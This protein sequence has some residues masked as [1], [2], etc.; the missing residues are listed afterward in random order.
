M[1]CPIALDL[2]TIYQ[3]SASK[4]DSGDNKKNHNKVVLLFQGIYKHCAKTSIVVMTQITIFL[5][6]HQ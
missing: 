2:D 4:F 6:S 3:V 5:I 1:L